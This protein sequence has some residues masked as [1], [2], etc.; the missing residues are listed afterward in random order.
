MA[1]RTTQLQEREE[2]FLTRLDV[3]GFVD[4]VRYVAACLPEDERKQLMEHAQT[5]TNE[6]TELTSKARDKKAQLE[7]ERQKKITDQ[8]GEEID[9]KLAGFIANQKASSKRLVVLVRS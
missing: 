9:L 5:L 3:S 7:T 1:A 8:P 4:E 6:Q 2:T